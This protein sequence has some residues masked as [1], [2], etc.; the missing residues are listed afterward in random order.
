MAGQPP[1]PAGVI[2]ARTLHDQLIADAAAADGRL[3]VSS[4]SGTLYA[5]DQE[6]GEILWSSKRLSRIYTSPI[7]SGD[8]VIQSAPDGTF[9]GL[10]AATGEERWQFSNLI[11]A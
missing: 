5:L 10:N 11:S 6:T 9:Y 8:T 3:F 2:W 1:L 7:V 4:L